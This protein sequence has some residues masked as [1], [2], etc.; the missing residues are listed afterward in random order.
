MGIVSSLLI[1]I[2]PAMGRHLSEVN[3]N[4]SVVRSKIPLALKSSV[5][6]RCLCPLKLSHYRVASGGV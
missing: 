2:P 5:E 6:C 1:P 4:C 3:Q